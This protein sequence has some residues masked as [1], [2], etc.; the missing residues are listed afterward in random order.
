MALVW[1]INWPCHVVSLSYGIVIGSLSELSSGPGRNSVAFM[2][3]GRH[4]ASPLLWLQ[5]YIDSTMNVNGT[6]Q[7]EYVG[8]EIL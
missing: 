6:L 7:N 4:V 1:D 5:A 2:T 3:S 8:W